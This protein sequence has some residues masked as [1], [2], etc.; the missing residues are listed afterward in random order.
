[1]L[2]V[3]N[4]PRNY[5]KRSQIR[6]AGVVVDRVAERPKKRT[7]ADFNDAMIDSNFYVSFRADEKIDKQK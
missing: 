1:M 3:K 4:S 2:K 7:D 6:P 5:L